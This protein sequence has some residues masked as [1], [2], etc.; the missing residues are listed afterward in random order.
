MKRTL[1]LLM[2]MVF[3]F[4]LLAGCGGKAPAMNTETTPGTT[5]A[6][7]PTQP[8]EEGKYMKI[9]TLGN[10]GIVDSCHMLAH[11]AAKE[12]YE[13]VKVATLYYS[14]CSL[15]QHAAF[16][17]KNA[18]DYKLYVSSTDDPNTAPTIMNSVTM[19][20]A[21]RYDYWDIIVMQG[22]C[23]EI[24]G[25]EATIEGNIQTIQ[26]YVR[27]N[28]LN[29]NA[30][31]VW[32]MGW[33]AP[34][35]NAL[36]DTYPFP[37][38]NVYYTRYVAYGDNRDTLYGAIVKCVQDKIIPN[39][40]FQYIIPTGTAMENALSSYLDE[41]D[42]HR[43]YYHV[44]DLIRVM[45]SYVWLCRIFGIEQLAELKVDAIPM[46][47]FNSINGV[48]DYVLTDAEKNVLLESINNALKT[49]FAMTQ[50]QYTTAP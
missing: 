2:A 48:Q 27:E 32:H 9:L 43:D 1:S 19:E 15:A 31:F 8:G 5:E 50:S 42:I 49:P 33:A 16:L 21:L 3:A 39:D 37:E 44:T 29:P 24:A 12:G 36:R 26:K 30:K 18:S 7:E 28:C 4:G 45:N 10:S 47:L 20:Q 25:Q 22:S 13:N 6:T 34:T 11:V 38:S 41:N 14:G 46:T 35:N 40:S 23:W 17:T